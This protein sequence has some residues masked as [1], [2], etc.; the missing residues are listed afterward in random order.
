MATVPNSHNHNIGQRNG[1]AADRL[2]DLAKVE[3]PARPQL[4]QRFNK[5]TDVDNRMAVFFFS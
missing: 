5:M 2:D 1:V 4:E 3:L